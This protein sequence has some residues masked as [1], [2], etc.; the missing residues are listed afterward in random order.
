VTL[1]PTR[2]LAGLIVLYL[3]VP[4]G[5]GA[6]Q[7]ASMS[8]KFTPEKLGA[9]TTLTLGFQIK[10]A[11]GQIPPPL[12]GVDFHYPPNLGF[13][14]SGLGL[15]TCQP[16]ELQ[17]HGPTIC[18][19]NSRMGYGTAVAEIPFGGELITETASL[20]LLA[21]P[22]HDG[23]VHILICAT[24][25]SPVAA[26][27][28]MPTTL[29]A[30]HLHIAVPLVP[31]LPGAPDVAVVHIQVTLGANLTY[32]EH[33]QGQTV[34]YH[35]KGIGLPKRCPRGGFKFATTFAF[36][37]GSVASAHTTVACPRHG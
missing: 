26:R 8:A 17:E 37:D 15:A 3:A 34:A 18:P 29:L 4:S 12:T 25:L 9:A 11:S 32:Y 21:G 6:A 14:T 2:I 35:P 27:V 22:S 28:V 19:A 30:G 23:Y 13:V 31:S 33:K 20:A 7:T 24:G 1:P 36:L 16:E 10:G 5:A